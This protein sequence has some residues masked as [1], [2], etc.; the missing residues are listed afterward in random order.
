M[1]TPSVNEWSVY[2]IQ[3]S[4]QRLYTGIT[5]NM[6]NR[7]RKHHQKK[8]AKFFYGRSPLALCY[9][10]SGHCRSSASKREHAIKQLSRQQ[11]WQLIIQ[12]YGPHIGDE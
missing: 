12:H 6:I 11:K 7:W 1:A 8:G 5:N 2:I 3:A 10:E 4:D 9:Q